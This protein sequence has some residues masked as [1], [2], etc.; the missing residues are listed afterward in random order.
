MRFNIRNVFVLMAVVA[1]GAAIARLLSVEPIQIVTILFLLAYATVPILLGVLSTFFQNIPPRKREV[2]GNWL[3]L[4]LIGLPSL[5]ILLLPFT[6]IIG[7]FWIIQ[8]PFY[9]SVHEQPESNV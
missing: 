7:F 3:M 8:M 5:T 4:A 2:A 6:M 9:M 1:V